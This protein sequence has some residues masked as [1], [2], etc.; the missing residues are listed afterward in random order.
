M[1]VTVCEREEEDTCMSHVCVC[2]CERERHECAWLIK[3][4]CFHNVSRVRRVLKVIRYCF[5]FS[6]IS[7]SH[8]PPLQY[9]ITQKQYPVEIKEK[10]T[11]S[12]V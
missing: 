9:G 3:N 11:V 4:T 6:S 12:N 8:I 10:K 2:V 5:F 1:C 7:T